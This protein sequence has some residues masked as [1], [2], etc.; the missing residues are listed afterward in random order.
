MPNVFRPLFE[1][2]AL[3]F[4]LF[5]IV[6]ALVFIYKDQY[7]LKKLFLVGFFSLLCIVSLVGTHFFPFMVWDKFPNTYPQTETD[8]E[9]RVVTD[10]DQ[11]LAYDFRAT[12]GVDGVYEPYL[13]P[14]MVNEYSYCRNMQIMEY[15]L[16]RARVY[17]DRVRERSILTFTRFPPHG[18]V[19][20]WTKKELDE[21][22]EFTGL[23]LYKREIRSSSDGTEVR[24]ISEETVIGYNDST[25]YDCPPET[26]N[27][28]SN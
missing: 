4:V 22:G 6:L 16:Q 21:Y 28:M 25:Q 13:T 23:R 2:R 1:L 27:R 14:K 17:R 12:L 19:Y 3:W 5:Y 10:D 7:P 9:L 15:L 11:E 18:L 24:S 26:M 20:I 8:Y